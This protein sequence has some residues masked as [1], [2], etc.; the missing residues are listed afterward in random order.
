MVELEATDDA[1][2]IIERLN[3]APCKI[4]RTSNVLHLAETHVF[5]KRHTCTL[6]ERA[7]THEPLILRKA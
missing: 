6:A 2:P 5:F 1:L 7:I 4:S 3:N